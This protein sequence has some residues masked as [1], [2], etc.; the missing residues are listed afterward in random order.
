MNHLSDLQN[1][2]MGKLHELL[3]ANAVVGEPII[4]GDGVTIIPVSRVKIGYAGGGSDF[5]PKRPTEGADHPFGGGAGA[6]IAMTPMAFLIIRGESVRML[7]V[8]EPAY[9]S[10]DRVIELIPDIVEKIETFLHE[11]KTKST[12]N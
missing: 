12:E 8:P 5:L 2:T 10:L 4:A 9:S 3:D 7:P 6:S 11:Q 1:A